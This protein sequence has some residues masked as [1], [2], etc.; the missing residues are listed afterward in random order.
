MEGVLLTCSD[1]H[2]RRNLQGLAKRLADKLDSCE[3]SGMALGYSRQTCLTMM[4]QTTTT[5]INN[6]SQRN[7]ENENIIRSSSIGS[8]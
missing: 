2:D 4:Q 3:K 7:I 5:S 6:N 8:M 1:L